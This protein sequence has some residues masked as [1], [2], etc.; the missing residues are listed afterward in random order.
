MDDAPEDI[1]KELKRLEKEG[2]NA[3][4][5]VEK[6]VF[7][8]L[9]ENKDIVEK[10]VEAWGEGKKNFKEASDDLAKDI[11]G[12]FLT[13]WAIRLALRIFGRMPFM[14]IQ[15]FETDGLEDGEEWVEV[16]RFDGTT[17]LKKEKKEY[18]EN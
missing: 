8:P 1:Q 11:G 18:E 17:Y 9:E 3:D 5:F 4:D 2:T 6:H 13:R 16:H 7:K 12:N 15:S 10:H 14:A